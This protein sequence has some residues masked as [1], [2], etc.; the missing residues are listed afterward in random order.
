[1]CARSTFVVGLSRAR[2]LCCCRAPLRPLCSLSG[3]PSFPAMRTVSIW[4]SSTVLTLARD[5]GRFARPPLPPFSPS[6]IPGS[7]C[8][9]RTASSQG[10]SVG[11]VCGGTA[12]GHGGMMLDCD[13]CHRWF[14]GPCVGISSQEVRRSA[15]WR[16][17]GRGRGV[18]SFCAFRHGCGRRSWTRVQGEDTFFYFLFFRHSCLFTML[19]WCLSVQCLYR[20]FV[21]AC[22]S[23]CFSLVVLPGNWCDRFGWIYRFSGVA[24]PRLCSPRKLPPPLPPPYLYLS[25]KLFLHFYSL[26]FHED[27]LVSVDLGL[28][29][30]VVRLLLFHVLN[31]AS[32]FRRGLDGNPSACDHSWSMSTTLSS[33]FLL[34]PCT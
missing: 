18:F 30:M 6:P 27:S 15:T 1:M 12:G 13:R 33:L 2:S 21:H 16:S 9:S 19:S 22:L 28:V 31:L 10:E 3:Y 24:F 4:I 23:R 34:V 14:H 5:R 25:F 26:R 7:G 29:R 11:C 8:P 32:Y 17:L 20:A